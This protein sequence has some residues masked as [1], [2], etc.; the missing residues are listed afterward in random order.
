[1]KT[2][3]RIRFSTAVA[4][5]LLIAWCAIIFLV[6]NITKLGFYGWLS[7][8]FVPA[9]LAAVLYCT[10]FYKPIKNDS[11][12]VALPIHYSF[13]LIFLA[14]VINAAFIFA[15]VKEA[16]PFV[17]AADVL[18]LVAYLIM[19]LFAYAY[20]QNLPNKMRKVERN[21][22]FS[23]TVSREL[24]TLLAQVDNPELHKALAGLKEKVDY[25]TNSTQGTY[26]EA[27]IL[28][29]LDELKNAVAS[30]G[31]TEAIKELISD[32][33]TLWKSRNTKL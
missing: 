27:P 18:L 6:G 12:A 22:S 31:D 1:M 9:C 16:G 33:T 5:L 2:N 28:A 29:K 8:L 24:G 11:S 7:F 25:S 26:D 19:A 10:A 4:G 23:I 30:K 15:G 20:L 21:T 13:V 17:I 14:V 32:V 3:D